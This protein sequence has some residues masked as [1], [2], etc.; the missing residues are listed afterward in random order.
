MGPA[1][2]LRE[3]LWLG[4]P[5]PRVW[6]AFA[7]PIWLAGWQVERVEGALEAGGAFRFHFDSLGLALDL[8]VTER[9]EPDRLVLA[10][11]P[12]GRTHQTQTVQ[13][14]ARDGG[15]E[16]ELCHGG[17][18]GGAR[19]ED[20]RAGTAAGWYTALR[21]LR[22]YLDR[23]AG[24]PR[25][26]IAALAP[27]AST[28]QA[29]WPLLASEAGLTRWLASDAALGQEGEPVR[30]TTRGGLELTGEVLAAAP[31]YQLALSLEEVAGVVEL[32]SIRLAGGRE[33]L[34]GPLLVGA[35]AS[36][37]DPARPAWQALAAELEEAVARLTDAL[38]G[39]RGGSA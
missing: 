27:A 12:P 16:V 26:V 34:P 23:H 8:E 9:T 5:P 3:R 29:A 19:G 18:A 13:L 37:W 28:P 36:S 15:T 2:E 33:D 22:L 4:H 7:D 38:G 24:Q 14:T 32:R 30:L 31:P 1:P 17:L 39:A 35:Q 11:G 20:E 6:R 10:G 21:R 25:A